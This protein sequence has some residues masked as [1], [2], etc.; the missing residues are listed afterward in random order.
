MEEQISI[1]IRVPKSWNAILKEEATRQS[2]PKT[3]EA[4]VYPAIK[5]LVKRIEKRKETK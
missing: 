3:R 2:P 4:I 5:S 1:Q